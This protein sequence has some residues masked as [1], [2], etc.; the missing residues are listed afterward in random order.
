MEKEIGVNLMSIEVTNRCNL[1]CPHCYYYED[2]EKGTDYN[3]FIDLKAVDRLF[4]DMKIKYIW[5]LN[6]TGG[7]PLLAEDKIIEILHKIIKEE[8]LVISIDIATN[9]TILSEKFAHELNEFSKMQYNFLK[10]HDIDA[11]NNIIEELD[12]NKPDTF[13]DMCIVNLRISRLWHDNKPEKAYEFY[14]EKMPNVFVEII[15]E[16]ISDEKFKEIYIL[17]GNVPNKRRIAY[18]G[19]AKNLTNNN[20]YCD[21]LYHKIVYEN[22]FEVKCPLEMSYDGKISIGGTCSHCCRENAAIGSVFDGRSLR[23]MI[24]DWN[25][26]TP[27]TCDE[28]CELEEFHMAK[29]LGND[30][31]N[32]RN[33]EKNNLTDEKIE[34]GV[35]GKELRMFFLKNYR[36]KLHEKI[37]CLTPEELET[38]SLYA[39]DR[40]ES[41][42]SISEEEY[43]KIGKEIDFEIA[44]LAWE[45]DFDDVKEIHEA[46]PY[47]TPEE[48][49]EL[50]ECKRKV[51]PYEDNAL[52]LII[53]LKE[54]K[55][56]ME[57]E[58]LNNYREKNEK[59][60][61]D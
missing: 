1:N 11:I 17:D 23:K 38:I 56:G 30:W 13:P 36:L 16:S 10:K 29:E 26:K 55:R 20:F 61:F 43:E 21:S 24:T 51:E 58:Y 42:T 12:T 8:I 31:F 2:G 35:Y 48:C 9:G 25:Y 6:F 18:S 57:L 19:R 7:E 50:K 47:L 54:L 3:D 28:A 45:H 39:L 22:D 37:P 5:T 41:A 60:V 49:R 27:L 44:R 15:E 32:R 33:G 52:G 14:K 46:Y 53:V 40:E 59:N 4:N 34:K